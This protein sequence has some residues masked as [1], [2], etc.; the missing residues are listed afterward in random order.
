M[1]EAAFVFDYRGSVLFWHLPS[2]RSSGALP[3]SRDLWDVLWENR[4]WLG[5]VA[6][7][8]PWSGRS[9]PS[10][11]DLTT[12]AACEKGLGKRLLWPIVTFDHVAIYQ[13]HGSNKHD[14]RALPEELAGLLF[15]KEDIERLRDLSRGRMEKEND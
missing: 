9:G 4:E 5:G 2:A 11:T 12:F 8:H 14:Y 7:T 15:D 10:G 6:H 1:L 13:W 3:D